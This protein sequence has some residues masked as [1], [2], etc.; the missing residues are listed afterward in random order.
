MKKNLLDRFLESSKVTPNKKYDKL[1]T[2][3][4]PQT[5]PPKKYNKFDLQPNTANFNQFFQSGDSVGSTSY[6]PKRTKSAPVAAVV[7]SAFPT[8]STTTYRSFFEQKVQ[9]SGSQFKFTFADADDD[10]DTSTFTFASNALLSSSFES[11]TVAKVRTTGSLSIGSYAYT[12]SI[13]DTAGNTTLFS[14]SFNIFS[15]SLIGFTAIT[16]FKHSGSAGSGSMRYIQSPW[17]S[18]TATEVKAHL[19]G[20][21][22]WSGGTTKRIIK[23]HDPMIATDQIYTYQEEFENSPNTRLYIQPS[24]NDLVIVTGSANPTDGGDA[25]NKDNTVVHVVGNNTSTPKIIVDGSD[26]FPIISSW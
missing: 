12:G 13:A 11:A 3:S 20:F 24:T 14:S 2:Q 15:G 8:V 22:A 23:E 6:N 26:G 16:S 7:S 10:L 9:L 1:S 4:I 18:R 5:R 17:T 25:G 19:A 21:A